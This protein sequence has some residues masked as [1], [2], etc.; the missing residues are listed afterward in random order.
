MYELKREI[1]RLRE[2]INKRDQLQEKIIF[3]RST[4]SKIIFWNK[5]ILILNR[6]YHWSKI[7]S[8]NVWK[9]VQ[10]SVNILVT[11]KEKVR[12]P[13]ILQKK[14]DTD[15]EFINSD[16][17]PTTCHLNEQQRKFYLGTAET[18]AEKFRI[19]KA[20][21]I[22]AKQGKDMPTQISKKK[23]LQ[24]GKKVVILGDAPVLKTRYSLEERQ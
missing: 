2:N 20:H 5:K 14:K 4:K 21:E 13:S 16:V 22:N 19:S 11:L 8:I 1:N 17:S 23:P 12:K 9:S 18:E 3:I 15:C 10:V 24:N 7:Q 6:N